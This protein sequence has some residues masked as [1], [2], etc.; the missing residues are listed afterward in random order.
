MALQIE[1]QKDSK[2]IIIDNYDSFTFNI[3]HYVEPLV[4]VC[5]VV[6][7]DEVDIAS[8][9]KYDKIIFSPG[10]GLPKEKPIL[11]KILDHYQNTKPIL[12][13][14]FGHQAIAEYYGSQLF[15]MKEV[16]HG[17]AR[18]TQITHK[19]TLWKELP[20]HFE[21]GRYHSWA[22]KKE[23]LSSNLKIIA[24][25]AETGVIM[26]LSHKTFNIKSVQFHPESILTEYGKEMIRNWIFE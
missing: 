6:N 23:G 17:L 21:T 14:C 13:I 22:V 7:I 20:S 8:L 4:D 2:I 11:W 3:Q 18:A 15:N 16:H 19:D 12:G 10:P 1:Q 5:D 9:S 26:G 25:D 24:E